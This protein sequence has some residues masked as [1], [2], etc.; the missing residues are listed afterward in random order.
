MNS[1]F[2]T[3]T[4]IISDK[5]DPNSL[6]KVAELISDKYDL[7]LSEEQKKKYYVT[8]TLLSPLESV[9]KDIKNE[10]IANYNEH[11]K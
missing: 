7:G 8:S 4:I 3:L 2:D 1:E 6:R 5:T 9:P 10:F 11:K